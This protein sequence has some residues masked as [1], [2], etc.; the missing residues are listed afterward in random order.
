MM[1]EDSRA[2]LIVIENRKIRVDCT[3]I[4]CAAGRAGYTSKRGI[5]RWVDTAPPCNDSLPAAMPG[6]TD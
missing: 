3:A 5:G 2:E 1:P 4:C 6:G